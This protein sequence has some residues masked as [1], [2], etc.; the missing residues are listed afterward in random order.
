MI[1]SSK[2]FVK[3]KKS[4][5]NFQH[6]FWNQSGREVKLAACGHVSASS[7]TLRFFK[8][9]LWKKGGGGYIGFGLSVIPFVRLSVRSS[10]IIFS[11]PLNIF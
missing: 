7:Q 5:L 3:K 4:I 8:A 1:D 11:F 2:C 10:V 6:R 9:P